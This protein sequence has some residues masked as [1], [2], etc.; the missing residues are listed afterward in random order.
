[1]TGIPAG[2]VLI[3]NPSKCGSSWL[4]QGMTVRPYMAFPREFDFLYFI[5]F[6]LDRQWN[7]GTIE[8]E[9]FLQVR[10]NDELTNDEK[11]C[12]LYE[13]E[14]QRHSNVGW[15]IDKAPSN[16][17]NFMTYRHLFR[18]TPT[19]LLYRDP[20]DV[21]VSNEFYHQRQLE[22]VDRNENIGTADYLRSSHVFKASMSNCARLQRIEKQLEEDGVDA[23]KITYEEM[24]SDFVAVVTRV[25]NSCGVEI[26]DDDEVTSNYVETPIPFAEHLQRARDFK[27]L[28]RKGV[29]GDWK[30]YITTPEA[31]DFVKEGWGDLLIELGYETG[32]DW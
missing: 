1:M 18:D 23:L 13:I 14:R 3:L 31:K 19:V 15:L 32:T 7:A 29:T 6:P 26:A 24:K 10:A 2:F 8:D 12:S 27:P 17:H 25:I 21:F 4:A 5:G 22:L 30:N 11:L 9:E 16:I 20:R 28:F